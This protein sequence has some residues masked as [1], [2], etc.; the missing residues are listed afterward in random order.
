LDALVKPA[1]SPAPDV[2]Q[3][4]LNTVFLRAIAQSGRVQHYT[5]HQVILNEGDEGDSLFII[6][7]GRVKSYSV[8]SRTAREV[9]FRVLS[10][11][12]YFGELTLDGGHHATSIMAIEPTT[13]SVVPAE[14]F[15]RFVLQN[16]D[17]ALNLIFKLIRTVRDSTENIKGLA[18]DDVHSRV[19]RLLDS[20]AD[21][22]D[23]R[24]VIDKRVT[25]QDMAHRIGSSREM[26]S[27]VLRQLVRDGI[28]EMI[29]HRIVVLQDPPVGADTS[30]STQ[31]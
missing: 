10:Q 18:L 28:I 12:E 7:S 13:L 20:M 4:P 27:R 1:A 5:N 16:P 11:G 23:G 24:R 30:H 9:V 19:L 29:G 2:Q 8:S 25:Q 14:H 3:S 17:F 21:N 26:V 15:R 22:V 6:L 31:N